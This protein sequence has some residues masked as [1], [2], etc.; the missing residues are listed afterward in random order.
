M[1]YVDN[2]KV[3]DKKNWFYVRFIKPEQTPFSPSSFDFKNERVIDIGW[4]NVEYYDKWR[5]NEHHVT[6]MS[7]YKMVLPLMSLYIKNLNFNINDFNLIKHY[8]ENG[9]FDVSYLA[10]K[11][12]NLRFHYERNGVLL[13]DDCG[14]D[15]LMNI[16][17]KWEETTSKDG[18]TEYHNIFR[19][20]HC[21]NRIINKTIENNKKI[22]ITGDSMIAPC[23]PIISCYYKEV[24]YMDNREN[25]SHKDYYEGTVFD[26]VIVQVWEGHPIVKQLFINLR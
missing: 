22:F 25:V 23:I 16:D 13:S 8:A 5:I 26:D 18:V 21:C 10:P 12:Q 19:G 20:T 14:F 11:N 1:G 24:V 3:K 2:I 7:H 9:K 6:T 17:K 4:L 15:G